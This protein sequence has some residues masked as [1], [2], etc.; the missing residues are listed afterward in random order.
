MEL[1]FFFLLVL[2]PIIAILAGMYL[3]IYVLI[4]LTLICCFVF[5]FKKL[6]GGKGTAAVMGFF[7]I[8]YF[9][10]WV[11]IAWIIGLCLRGTATVLVGTD[12]WSTIIH[13]LL[14]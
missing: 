7:V 9:W 10:F 1:E 13:Y 4:V 14:R 11:F 12:I 3:S 6:Q 2:P 8:C 5:S